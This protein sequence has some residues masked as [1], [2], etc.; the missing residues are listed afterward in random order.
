MDESLNRSLCTCGDMEDQG[1]N[2]KNQMM[3]CSLGAK[4]FGH[5]QQ[6]C[7]SIT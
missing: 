3:H 6:V 4:K 5:R 1:G 7:L 2:K